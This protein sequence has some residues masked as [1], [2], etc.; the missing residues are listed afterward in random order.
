MKFRAS[1]L[2]CY[3]VVTRDK[4]KGDRAARLVYKK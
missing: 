3:L 1:T 4:N 2:H